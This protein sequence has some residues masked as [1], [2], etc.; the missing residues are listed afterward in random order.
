M[1]VKLL[2]ATPCYGGALCLNYVTSVLRL[3]AA[4][5]QLDMEHEFHFRIDSLVT[6]AR[7]DCVAYF[8]DGDYTHLFFIDADIGFDPAAVLRLVQSGHD[9][10][11]GIYP[12]KS[13]GAGFPIDLETLGAVDGQGFAEANEAPTGFMCVARKVFDDLRAAGIGRNEVF[14]TMH[15]GDDYLSE[16]YAFCRRWRAIGGRVYVDS[17]SNL[18]HQGAKLFIRNFE[19]YWSKQNDN[20]S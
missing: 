14:D 11:A 17:H 1:R 16:D 8:L 5:W 18:T 15:E 20:R 19:Q 10:V 9:V 7:N 2:I 13:E 12:I 6:R 3:R 4:L